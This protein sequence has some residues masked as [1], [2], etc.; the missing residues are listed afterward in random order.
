VWICPGLLLAV[1]YDLATSAQD[2]RE[3]AV[4][5]ESC[6]FVDNVL[7]CFCGVVYLYV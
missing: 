4:H 1:M 2:P 3:L 6:E 5:F 7:K